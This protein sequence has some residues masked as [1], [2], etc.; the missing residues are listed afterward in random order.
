MYN[1]RQCTEPPLNPPE[2]PDPPERERWAIWEVESLVDCVL[3]ILIGQSDR[4][5]SEEDKIL[6]SDKS[7]EEIRVH[8]EE[9][10]HGK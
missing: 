1:Y 7:L 5:Y 2:Y 8:I 10:N 3:N 6:K 9:T 4:D